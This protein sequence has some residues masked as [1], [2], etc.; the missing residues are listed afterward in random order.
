LTLGFSEANSVSR[1]AGRILDAITELEAEGFPASSAERTISNVGA[2]SL[3]ILERA[4]G[5]EP[6]TSSFDPLS[7]AKTLRRRAGLSSN[8]FSERDVLRY[9]RR[10]LRQSVELRAAGRG[11]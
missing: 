6:V 8:Y 4:T 9:Q 10:A 2:K 1:T 3:G 11:G 5:I 7:R